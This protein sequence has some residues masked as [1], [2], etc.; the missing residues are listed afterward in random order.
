MNLDGKV[1]ACVDELDEEREFCSGLGIDLL[2]E[3]LSLV[4]LGKL[5]DGLAGKSAFRYNGFI[6]LYA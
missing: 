3:E 1:V 4:L 5:C 2:S 6:A